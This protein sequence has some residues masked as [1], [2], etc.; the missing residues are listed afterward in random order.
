MKSALSVVIIVCLVVSPLAGCATIR[1]PRQISANP[2]VG[3]PPESDWSRV[4][5]LAPAKEIAV[6]IRGS[7]PANRYFVLADQSGVIVLNLTGPTLPGAATRVLRDMASQH[8]EY[9]AAIQQSG[10]LRQ[11][12]VS[13]GRDGVFVAN[14]KVADLGQVVE[15]FARN[16]VLEITG[17]VVARGSALGAVLGGWLGF[18]VGAVAGLGGAPAG[19]AWSVL[20]GSVAVGGFLGSHWSSHETEGVIYRVP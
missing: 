2:G 3:T 20:I 8:Q 1:G 6:T 12:N 9:F 10:T 14:R 15:T 4:G 19:L 18:S 7:Q 13:V 16:D 5:E 17:P 11:D